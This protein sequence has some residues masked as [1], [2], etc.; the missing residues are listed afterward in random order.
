MSFIDAKN[1]IYFEGVDWGQHEKNTESATGCPA[2]YR[3]Q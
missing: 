2:A 1:R 3:L